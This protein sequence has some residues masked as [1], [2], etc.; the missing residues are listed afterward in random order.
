MQM[1]RNVRGIIVLTIIYLCCNSL[2][3]DQHQYCYLTIH[4]LSCLYEFTIFFVT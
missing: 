4:Q 3:Q 2:S 1:A